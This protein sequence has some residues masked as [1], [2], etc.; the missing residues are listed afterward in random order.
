VF[1]RMRTMRNTSM[2]S[3]FQLQLILVNGFVAQG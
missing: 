3:V 1:G 2:V